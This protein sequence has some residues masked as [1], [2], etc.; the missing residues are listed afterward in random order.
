MTSRRTR[1]S[2]GALLSQDEGWSLLVSLRPPRRWRDLPWAG[3]RMRG[4]FS[5]ISTRMTSRGRGPWQASG[6]DS[7]GHLIVL[8]VLVITFPRWHVVTHETEKF[9]S[10]PPLVCIYP[11]VS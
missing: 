3:C 9:Y 2:I 11:V 6:R 10:V 8:S 5:A 7:Q 1:V 4:E